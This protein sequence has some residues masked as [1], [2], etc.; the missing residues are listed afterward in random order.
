MAPSVAS[1]GG[2][3]PKG[4][5]CVVHP[6]LDEGPRRWKNASNSPSF[7]SYKAKASMGPKAMGHGSYS[8]PTFLPSHTAYKFGCQMN[9]S[10]NHGLG[11]ARQTLRQMSVGL[12]SFSPQLTTNL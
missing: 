9:T 6:D 1:K 3:I 2:S 11:K 8:Q 12:A 5:V 7:C 4:G 10:A